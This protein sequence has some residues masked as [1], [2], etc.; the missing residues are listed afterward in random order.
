MKNTEIIYGTNA[1]LE[2]LRAKK[3]RCHKIYIAHGRRDKGVEQIRKEAEKQGLAV[4]QVPKQEIGR[5]AGT[6]KHQ[7]VALRADEFPNGALEDVIDFAKRVDE[8]GLIL[9]LDGIKDPQNLGALL[10]TACL[11]GVHGV[12]VPRD[13]SAKITPAVVKASAG[14][15]EHV[16]IAQVINITG[17]I[18]TLKDAG[19]WVAGACAGGVKS[20]YLH[21]FTGY[22][23]AVV[24]GSEGV[25]IRRLVRKHCDFLLEIPM[26]G[27][28]KSYNVSV[29][30]AIFL[31]E[32]V[33]QRWASSHAKSI[34]KCPQMP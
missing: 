5:L 23:V 20:V 10:R 9:I 11:M 30:G 6:D 16:N 7:G 22:N 14:A 33:R 13:N 18:R 29:A 25:G 31:S 21:D 26:R 24:L 4:S 32:I 19:F 12:I 8:E 27:A 15:S 28:V 17:T 34:S 2:V 3:R 1:V